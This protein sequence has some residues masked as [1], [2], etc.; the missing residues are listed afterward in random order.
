MFN[1]FLLTEL[2]RSNEAEL[3]RAVERHRVL[4]ERSERVASR[5][6]LRRLSGRRLP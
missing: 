5:S 1:H 2:A 6:R 3:Q 4:V